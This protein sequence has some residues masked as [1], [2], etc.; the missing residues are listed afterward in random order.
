MAHSYD[1]YIQS[2]KGKLG[3]LYMYCIAVLVGTTSGKSR[4][5][6]SKN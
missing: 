6:Q 3:H 2:G 4:R 5:N 1:N